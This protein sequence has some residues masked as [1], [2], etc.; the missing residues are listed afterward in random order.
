MDGAT[1]AVLV[2][3]ASAGCVSI[4]SQVQ[5]SKCTKISCCFGLGNCERDVR[6]DS[7][8]PPDS[9]APATDST[10]PAPV[11]TG[12]IEGALARSV[13]TSE[14]YPRP[15]LAGIRADSPRLEQ[16]RGFKHIVNDSAHR[17]GA[18]C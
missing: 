13:S 9:N 17:D 16:P 10:D 7:D 2:S 5:H 6:N 15:Q 4:L 18:V 12:N 14:R 8:E 3:A 1:I 11:P